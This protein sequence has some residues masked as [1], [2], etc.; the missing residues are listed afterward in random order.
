MFIW[1][2][3]CIKSGGKSRI[4]LSFFASSGNDVRRKLYTVGIH[5]TV[6]KRAKVM[7]DTTVDTTLSIYYIEHF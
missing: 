7:P 1:G 3:L 5:S 4:S 6:E 2:N